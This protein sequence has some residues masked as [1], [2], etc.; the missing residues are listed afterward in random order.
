MPDPIDFPDD[1]NGNVFRRMVRAGDDL[2]KPRLVDFCHIFPE[3]QQALAFAEIVDDR[4]LEVC[5]AY[6]EAREMWQVTVK[7]Y[8]VPTY[9]DVT[10][11][12]LLLAS[13]AE[14]VGGKSDGWG[15]LSENGK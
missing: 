13:H 10:T 11:L 1:E 7:R 6:Y 9:Q 12:E 5:I 15:C 3:R 8:M 2:S 4:D 14:F